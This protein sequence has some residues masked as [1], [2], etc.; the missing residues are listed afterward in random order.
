MWALGVRAGAQGLP[1]AGGCDSHETPEVCYRRTLE[2]A[3][4]SVQGARAR[5]DTVR[6]NALKRQ[7]IAM[8]IQTCQRGLG[9][10]CYLAGRVVFDAGLGDLLAE[11]RSADLFRD[12]CFAAHRSGSACEG[13]AEAY[14]YGLGRPANSDSAE[15]L[16]RDACVLQNA[17]ACMQS[18]SLLAAAPAFDSAGI[19]LGQKLLRAA[20]TAESMLGCIDMAYYMDQRLE[21][22]TPAAFG[23]Q[24]YA[25]LRDSS[26]QLYRRACEAG[27]PLGCSNLGV[28]F[29][30]ALGRPAEPDSAIFYYQV[31]C[32]EPV[33]AAEAGTHPS[34]NASSAPVMK[35]VRGRGA[36][37]NN[38][39]Y[40]LT[41][42]QFAR[43][44]TQAALAYFEQGCV[45]FSLDA[46]VNRIRLDSAR[47]R[48][49]LTPYERIAFVARA[50]F[51]G[52]G[53]G[54]DNLGWILDKTLGDSGRAGMYYGR[55][56]DLGDSNGCNNLG[57]L[58]EDRDSTNRALKYYRRACNLRNSLGC[59]NMGSLLDLGLHQPDLALPY[60]TR[61]CELGRNAG[62]RN[63]IAGLARQ[64]KYAEEARYRTIF[65]RNDATECK[66]KRLNRGPS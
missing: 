19:A 23:S 6:R 22:T 7:A 26:V 38:L 8:M 55:A 61:A 46:C 10:G 33:Q 32:Q 27:S 47:G 41:S 21:R 52:S 35:G 29:D 28:D 57:F 13:L 60:Y 25:Q 48:S 2:I 44:D 51:E 40:L 37:C 12:G 63:A 62:C 49:T 65:C 24:R 20:C 66:D 42:G 31:A 39:G 54:C 1:A 30:G 58:N 50:C 15:A 53:Y 56:C 36:A 9:A 5:G 14:G 16:F 43:P 3:V 45:A 18:G 17:T 64:Q 11:T 59:N 34:P 4:D